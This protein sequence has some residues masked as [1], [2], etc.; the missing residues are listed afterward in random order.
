M[1]LTIVVSPLAR[2]AVPSGFPGHLTLPMSLIL[3]VLAFVDDP[4]WVD[5]FACTLARITLP[6]T[7]VLGSIC[8]GH[9]PLTTSLS[10]VPIADVFRAVDP[11]I[12][13]LTLKLIILPLAFIVSLIRPDH[14]TRTFAHIISPLTFIASTISASHLALSVPHIVGVVALVNVTIR[15]S[16]LA[17]TLT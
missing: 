3:E 5:R 2:I 14:T 7:L 9:G 8:V 1:A 11:K 15:P 4:I 6:F 10:F 16:L 12:A 17:E 13:S